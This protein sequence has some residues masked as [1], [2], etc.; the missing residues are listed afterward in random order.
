MMR[1][2]T[3]LDPNRNGKPVAVDPEDYDLDDLVCCDH[4]IYGRERK[5]RPPRHR[6]EETFARGPLSYRWVTS[7][8]RLPD[9]GLHVALTY[10]FLT[11]RWRRPCRWTVEGIGRGLRIS[12]RWARHGLQVGERAGILAVERKPGCR[13]EVS[14]RDDRRRDN[15]GQKPLYG[16]IAWKWLLPCLRLPGKAAHLAMAVWFLAGREWAAQVELAG[17]NWAD[18]GLT[19]FSAYR[20]LEALE[21]AGLVVVTRRC[22]QPPLVTILDVHK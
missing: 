21:K 22:G 4:S 3:N 2:A 18:F 8:C 19:R 15:S 12:E 16:P 1:T 14:V 5:T 7:A 10:W 13:L 17:L 9:P 6:P 11:C 20:G